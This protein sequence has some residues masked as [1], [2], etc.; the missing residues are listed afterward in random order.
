MLLN[1][2]KYKRKVKQWEGDAGWLEMCGGKA[3]TLLNRAGPVWL[4]AF[5]HHV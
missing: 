1:A 3:A 5:C 2:D 4:G